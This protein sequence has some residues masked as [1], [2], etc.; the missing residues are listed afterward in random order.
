MKLD[1]DL[2]RYKNKNPNIKIVGIDSTAA[3][4]NKTLQLAEI[5][6][7]VYA[8]ERDPKRAKVLESRVTKANEL[9]QIECLNLDFMEN[10]SPV[11][12]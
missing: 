12:D 7:K 9:G 3:P 1:K 11:N 6:N 2:K 5:C 8:F 10:E 4:G